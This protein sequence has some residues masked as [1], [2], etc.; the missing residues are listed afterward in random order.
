[1]NAIVLFHFLCRRGLD[2]TDHAGGYPII[3]SFIPVVCVIVCIDGKQLPLVLIF[4]IVLI[5]I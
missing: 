1:M 5:N 3:M 4:I 2:V